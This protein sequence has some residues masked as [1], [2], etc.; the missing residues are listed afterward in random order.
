[1]SIGQASTS[2]PPP[3]RRECFITVGATASFQALL[4][5]ALT[6][7]FIET[8][9][10]L[11]YTHLTVQC[12]PDL[13]YANSMVEDAK[14]SGL[15]FGGLQLKIF[16]FNKLGLGAEMRGSKGSA[17]GSREGVVICH[18]GMFSYTYFIERLASKL[19]SSI[20]NEPR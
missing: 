5:S 19:P 16:D 14:A 8:L 2:V 12:G 9:L 13:A 4:D 3:V 7:A 17:K 15:S 11:E 18:A 6:L 10:E 20:P 1:M